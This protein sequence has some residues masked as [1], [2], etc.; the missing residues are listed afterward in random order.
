[1]RNSSMC[2]EVAQAAKGKHELT[3]SLMDEKDPAYTTALFRQARPFYV[4]ADFQ[5]PDSTTLTG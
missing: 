5:P 2:E 1:M 3:L 4:A